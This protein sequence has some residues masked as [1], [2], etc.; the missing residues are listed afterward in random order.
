MRKKAFIVAAIYSILVIAFKLFVWQG[1][2][3]FDP[4]Y[5]WSHAFSLLAII[6]FIF[7]GV[8]WVRDSENG[9]YI[10]GKEAG[11]TGLTIALFSGIIL[12]AYHYI[13]FNNSMDIYKAYYHSKEY[14]DT[15]NEHDTNVIKA[16]GVEK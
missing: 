11:Q 9:G 7:F 1:G 3:T 13:E 15:I 6:P 2:H 14:M 12:F 4:A 16:G 10:S 5:R 8:K